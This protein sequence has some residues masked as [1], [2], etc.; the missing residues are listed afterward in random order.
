MHFAMAVITDGKPTEEDIEDILAPYQENNMGTTREEYLEFIPLDA[1]EVNGY[2]RDRYENATIKKDDGSEVSVK[3]T[4]SFHQYMTE[5]MC[6]EFKEE[7]NE[8]GYVANP[9]SEWDW[10]QI[11]GRYCA[12]LTVPIN[13]EGFVGSRS[14]TNDKDPDL[15]ACESKLHK[16]CDCARIKDL[17]FPDAEKKRARAERFWE[18]YVE[19]A[20]PQNDDEKK[21][22]EGFHSRK[23][24]Y[25]ERYKT[26]EVYAKCSS[27]FLMYGY[28]N[29]EGTWVTQDHRDGDMPSWLDEFTS[30][31][32]AAG[33]NDYVTIVDCHV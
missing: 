29:K 5:E 9:N 12:L 10:W 18:L 28:V 21:I 7:T 15:Y 24:Y 13:C 20:E 31:I 30:V 22:L 11:G 8:Y 25:L 14:W 1:N 32:E 27:S 17:V 33:E 23:E 6:Y 16:K 26:K 4:M 3:D 19:G 2:Y